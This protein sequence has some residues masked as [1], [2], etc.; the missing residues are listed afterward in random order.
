M[1]N[2]N[3]NIFP[4][5]I[6][7][8]GG[9]CGSSWLY[10]N[11]RKHPDIWMTPQKEIHYFDRSESYPSPN[12]FSE[13]N[14][15]K[16]LF[17]NSA[18]SRLFR[19]ELIRGLAGDLIKKRKRFIWDL[20]YFLGEI[21]DAW[22]ASLF[23]KGINKTKG[24]IT[25]AYSIL[26]SED[27]RKIKD[28]MPELKIIFIIRNPIYRTWSQLRKN[29][30]SELELG[31]IA[32]ILDSDDM[33]LRNDYLRTIKIWK[34]YFTDEKF[35]LGFYDD[36]SMNPRGL[37]LRIFR[38]LGVNT[39]LVDAI[40]DELLGRKIN[41]APKASIPLETKQLLYK[42]IRPNLKHISNVIGGH[43][44]QWEVEAQSDTTATN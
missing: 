1:D 26:R 37:I 29:K 22:Y 9:R 16:R 8:G 11:L 36:I 28:L 30:Q 40:D 2:Y 41:A 34:E 42:K 5:F 31:Q 12:R 27:V 7:I 35:F 39:N 20:N 4:E 15:Y 24:E 43:A 6:G 19:K 14:P 33:V 3:R 23:K 38:F 25:P 10:E 13:S 32:Q 17:G 44:R 21:N 18:K